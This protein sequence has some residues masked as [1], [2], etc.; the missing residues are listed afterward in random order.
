M[1]TD[2]QLEKRKQERGKS[3]KDK[4]VLVVVVVV[5]G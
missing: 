3:V 1:T 4:G 2:G 5:V